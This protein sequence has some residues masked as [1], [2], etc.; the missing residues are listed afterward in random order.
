MGQT[1]PRTAAALPYT[2]VSPRSDPNTGG[3]KRFTEIDHC[4]VKH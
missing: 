1:K 3:P 4:E 2:P